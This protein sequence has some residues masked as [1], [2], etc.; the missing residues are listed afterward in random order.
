K[1]SLIALFAAA[2]LAL[3]VF[4]AG[5]PENVSGVTATAVDT[6]SIGLSWDSAQDAEGGLVDHYRIYYGTTSVQQ[7][8][9]GEYDSEIDTANNATSYVIADLIADTEYF[10]SVT[11]IDSA[12]LESEAYSI[13]ASATTLAE[14]EGDSESPTVVEVSAVD[15]THVSVVFSETVVLP[16]LLPEA[17]FTITE[18]LTPGNMLEIMTAQL[19]EADETGATVVLETETQTADMNYIVTAGVAIQDEAGNPMISGSTD[20][21]LFLGSS[22]EAAVEAEEEVVAEEEEVME[23]EVVL[24]ETAMEEFMCGDGVVD[25][26]EECDDGNTASNDG[27]SNVCMEDEDTTP[28][29]DITSLLLSYVE[30]IETFMITMNWT[31]SINSAKDLVDQIMY[32]SMDRGM[33]YDEGTSLG[34]DAT[35]YEVDE[36]EGG[37][38][39][40]FKITTKDASGNESVGAVKSIRL[41][42]TGLGL[43]LL[44]MGSAA[45]AGGMLRRKRK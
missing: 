31:A 32:Q 38:E 12:D 9:E 18:Q 13:E 27:C 45:A 20:S 39:Y 23:E 24:E 30:Q 4:A 34:A 3:P 29:E 25:E 10:F 33:N 2:V 43:G 35:E 42:Q 1:K 40:T 5:E 26:G 16:I 22:L 15:N 37:Q 14:E 28:P 21:G 6:S 8:G 17:A 41:P 7:A 11:A 36:M 19:D 44:L